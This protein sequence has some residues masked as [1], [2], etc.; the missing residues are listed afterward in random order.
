MFP[1]RFETS[2]RTL[3]NNEIDVVLSQQ[4]LRTRGRLPA[5]AEFN[6]RD[7]SLFR[8][9]VVLKDGANKSSP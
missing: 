8:I 2:G 3:I 9:G 7:N 6:A 4:Y 1:L 5:P